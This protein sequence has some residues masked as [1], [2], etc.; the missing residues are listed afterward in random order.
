MCLFASS[1]IVLFLR[2][3]KSIIGKFSRNCK[4][5]PK[6]K[7]MSKLINTELEISLDETYDSNN[8]DEKMH[9]DLLTKK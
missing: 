9:K 3:V 2:W 7:K 8:F 6:E 1:I 5:V 4:V